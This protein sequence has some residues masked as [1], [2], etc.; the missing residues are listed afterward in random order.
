MDAA[1]AGTKE[2]GLVKKMGLRRGPRPREEAGV[3][4]GSASLR[5]T[6]CFPFQLALSHIRNTIFSSPEQSVLVIPSSF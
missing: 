2:G 3:D 5:V 4:F 1:V 6:V